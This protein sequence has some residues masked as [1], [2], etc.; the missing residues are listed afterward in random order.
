MIFANKKGGKKEKC[1]DTGGEEIHQSI[2]K[3]RFAVFFLNIFR[4]LSR[5]F[6]LNER[7]KEFLRKLLGGGK[8][9]TS[10]IGIFVGYQRCQVYTR[11]LP[12][13]VGTDI[14]GGERCALHVMT[15]ATEMM[16]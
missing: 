2:Q 14:E 10:C 3:T 7:F 6:K 8:I 15:S 13:V 16:T 5:L 11:N 4:K 12:A 1:V 9:D